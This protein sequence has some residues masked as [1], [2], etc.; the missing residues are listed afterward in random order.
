MS[1]KSKT[2]EQKLKFYEK[3]Y[4][5]PEQIAFYRNQ[6]AL[7]KQTIQFSKDGIYSQQGR[8]DFFT[9][10]KRVADEQRA[11]VIKKMRFSDDA[12][13]TSEGVAEYHAYHNAQEMQELAFNNKNI[14]EPT[15]DVST[16]SEN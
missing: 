2:S 8:E 14:A 15:A 9:H 4:K 6:L 10:H 16:Q 13:F 12:V 1:S 7:H 5:D 3:V 11:G